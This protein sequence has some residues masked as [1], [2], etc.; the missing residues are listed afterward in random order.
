MHYHKP[1]TID[2]VFRCTIWTQLTRLQHHV[3]F[4]IN[5]IRIGG[6]VAKDHLKIFEIPPNINS[7]VLRDSIPNNSL[8]IY[9]WYLLPNSM[10]FPNSH[11]FLFPINYGECM[12]FVG[13]KK[14]WSVILDVA[15]SWS[16]W[17]WRSNRPYF[18][19][20]FRAKKLY[21]YGIH[22]SN[23]NSFLFP[24]KDSLRP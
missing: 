24:A 5:G 20:Y 2:T 15:K 17:N 6:I 12:H 7:F 21:D 14:I 3:L 11:V 4:K 13:S 18:S 19:L 10:Y 16:F 9:H 1:W 23:R 8:F 22:D